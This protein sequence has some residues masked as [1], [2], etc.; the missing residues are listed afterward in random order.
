MPRSLRRSAGALLVCGTA[1]AAAAQSPPLVQT[2]YSA[3]LD[4]TLLFAV[5]PL[6]RLDSARPPT[7]P[8]LA[9][10]PALE[11]RALFPGK[12]LSGTPTV[13]AAAVEWFASL[14]RPLLT[15]VRFVVDDTLAAPIGG[16]WHCLR[17]PSGS[18]AFAFVSGLPAADIQ[19]LAEARSIVIEVAAARLRVT[20]SGLAVLRSFAQR[21]PQDTAD[22]R[23]RA[24]KTHIAYLYQDAIDDPVLPLAG[25]PLPTYPAGLERM[26][27]TGQVRVMLVVDTLGMPMMSTVKLI[28]SS[29]EQFTQA[30]MK[31]LPGYRFSPARACGL[32]IPQWVTMPIDFV[33]SPKPC[34]HHRDQPNC[35]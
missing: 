9:R 33:R 19:A 23:E 24:A 22:Q 6:A 4:S 31:V 7:T 12:D 29:N 13:V 10:A 2:R 1:L 28:N 17:P 11:L 26:E 35:T 32:L 15:G 25:N 5:V 27:T 14:P 21:L 8:P 20:D 34:T 3:V 16:R 30:V 18:G